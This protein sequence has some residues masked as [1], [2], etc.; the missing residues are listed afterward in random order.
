MERFDLVDS[1]LD[2]VGLS[3][4]NSD[5]TREGY[6]FWFG[7]FCSFIGKT[8]EQ[9]VKDYECSTLSNER[10]LIRKY[11][12]YIQ[13]FSSEL[14][15]KKLAPC[16]IGSAIGAV[17]SF[18]KYNDL[19]LGHIPAVRM[20]VMYHN[21]DI[22]HEEVKFI[23]D[24]SR[25]R[26]RAFFVVMA[27][28]GL[29]PDTIC[30]LRYKHIKQDLINHIIPC[31]IEI[32]EE[33]AKGK[34]HSYFTF[35][36]EEAVHHLQ[37]YLYTRRNITDEDYLLSSKGRTKRLTPNQLAVFLPEQFRSSKPED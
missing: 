25:P 10:Q 34:Y 24:A 6:K 23:L 36:G 33:I 4:S 5:R 7:Q 15:K 16:S 14:S 12:Q 18:F 30:S 29:R 13:A 37:S 35:I 11:A 31:K 9:I 26:E 2:N 8:P 1:W 21:R 20:R 17:K 22:T 19:T 28:S 32:P 3:H 27:Q